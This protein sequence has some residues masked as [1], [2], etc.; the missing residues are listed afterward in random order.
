[1]SIKTKNKTALVFGATG[2][3]GRELTIQLL[4]DDH[5]EKIITFVRKSS[6][7]IHPKLIE[8]IDDLSDPERIADQITGD[9]LFCCLGTTIKKAGSKKAFK[10]VNLELPVK[11]AEI[12]SRNEVKKFLVM[13]SVGAKSSSNNFYLR[14]KGLMESRILKQH[15]LQINI[16][17]PSILLGNRVEFRFGEEVGKILMHVLSFLFIG[18]LKKYKGIQ[19]VKVAKA[20]I[21]LAN[22]VNRMTVVDS[23]KIHEIGK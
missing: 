14:T 18:P 1:M 17:R 10:W 13:S 12:A 6:G 15:F 16:L 11:I 2:L 23:E 8:I 22:S 19:V 21:R 5:Y 3:T 20:M 4:C 7:L 9:D